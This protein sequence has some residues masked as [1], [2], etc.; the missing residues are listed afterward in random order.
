MGQHSQGAQPSAG[1]AE[2][3]VGGEDE[4]EDE[5]AGEG[6]EEGEGEDSSND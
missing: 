6:D 4:D 5:D 2:E 1:L 3:E